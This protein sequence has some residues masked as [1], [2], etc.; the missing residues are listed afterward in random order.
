[1]ISDIFIF[2]HGRNTMKKLFVI[3]VTLYMIATFSTVA[4]TAAETLKV[5][6]LCGMCK[7]RIEKAAKDIDGV[8]RAEWDKATKKLTLEFDS[9]KTK[10]ETISKAVARIGHDTEK[11]K[12]N[13][14][15]YDSLPG[16]CK[17]RK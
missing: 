3:F 14:N 4:L 5:E 12:A 16:C 1:M 15:V 6:G 17:Y 10:V 11:D 2:L 13:D 9:D 8:A 7:T